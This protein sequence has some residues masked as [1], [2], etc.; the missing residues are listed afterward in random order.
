MPVNTGKKE[1]QGANP[2]FPLDPHDVEAEISSWLAFLNK[3]DTR[4]LSRSREYQVML[5]LLSGEGI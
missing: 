5:I 1:C 2:P 3:V 4:T